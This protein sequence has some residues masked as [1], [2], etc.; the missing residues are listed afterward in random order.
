MDAELHAIKNEGD[1]QQT[2]THGAATSKKQKRFVSSEASLA[3]QLSGLK[4]KIKA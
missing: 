4:R 3:Q 1:N 2:S